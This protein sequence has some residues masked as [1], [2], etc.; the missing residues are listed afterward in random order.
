MDTDDSRG[1]DQAEFAAFLQRKFAPVPPSP[2]S[3]SP[4]S[5]ASSSPVRFVRQDWRTKRPPQEKMTAHIAGLTSALKQANGMLMS[6]QA[7]LISEREDST[8]VTALLRARMAGL[9]I[10]HSE[11]LAQSAS[12]LALA[13]GH[14]AAAEADAAEQRRLLAST[15]GALDA[16]RAGVQQLEARCAKAEAA[17]GA[18]LRKAASA[19]EMLNEREADHARTVLRCAELSHELSA[20]GRNH[21][22]LTADRRDACVGDDVAQLELA[23]ACVGAESAVADESASTDAQPEQAAGAREAA[24]QATAPAALTT[25]HAPYASHSS[26][27]PVQGKCMNRQQRVVRK[28]LKAVCAAAAAA[29]KQHQATSQQLAETQRRLLAAN[30]ELAEL[31]PCVGRDDMLVLRH[32]CQSLREQFAEVSSLREELAQAPQEM[33]AVAAAVEE[34]M[35][36]SSSSAMVRR[37]QAA[38]TEEQELHAVAVGRYRKEMLQRKAMY[39]R[40]MQ[41]KGN[42]RVFCR[43]R[44]LLD[45]APPVATTVI[46]S[47]QLP[48]EPPSMGMLRFDEDGEIELR[49]SSDGRRHR[50]EFDRLFEPEHGQDDVFEDIAPLLGS[51]VDGYDLCIFAYGQTGSG[52]TYTMEVSRPLA[53]ERLSWLGCI[54][55]PM[56]L[57]AGRGGARRHLLE[58]AVGGVPAARGALRGLRVQRIR[59][60]AG[61]LQRGDLRPAQRQQRDAAAR[62]CDGR[63]AAEDSY[64][65]DGRR[66]ECDQRSVVR[67]GHER[68]R[69]DGV[70]QHRQAEPRDRLH[71]LQRALL[72]LPLHPLFPLACHER[73]RGNRHRE[74]AA[75]D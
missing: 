74:Q 71:R 35:R 14:T 75:D 19:E 73:A 67:G 46:G 58:D 31:K 56:A 15:K 59:L 43:V 44:P 21:A 2:S 53:C 48:R 22:R 72:A 65:G 37:L 57:F 30:A 8:K 70:R 61:D 26:R 54:F 41:L 13:R 69:R 29:E 34:A 28:R 47:V 36:R 33:A 9:R 51:V 55:T 38:L 39:D 12:Q 17:E 23:D 1:V 63:R 5:S 3:V 42:I 4:A 60:D 18:A 50:F 64:P 52:K 10:R 16:S 66:Q 32:A 49:N 24:C 6:C 11:Q 25:A 45:V 27:V 20:H 62:G 7:T 68:G 40:L